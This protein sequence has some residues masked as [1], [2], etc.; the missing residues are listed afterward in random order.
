MTRAPF[1]PKLLVPWLAATVWT[2]ACAGTSAQVGPTTPQAET[3]GAV[4]V[5]PDGD[6]ANAAPSPSSASPSSL[7]SGSATTESAAVLGT[8]GRSGGEGDGTADPAAAPADMG[9][10]AKA[11]SPAVLAS[12]GKAQFVPAKTYRAQVRAWHTPPTAPPRR[13]PDGHPYLVLEAVNTQE[14]VELAPLRSDGGF[15]AVDLQRAA[16]LLRDHRA[17]RVLP[18]D[19]RALNLVYRIQVHFAAKAVR[20]LS[21]FRAAKRRPSNHSRGRAIDLMVPGTREADVASYARTLGFVGVGIYPTSGFVHLDTRARSYFWVDSSGPGQRTR[22]RPIY[23]REA[24]QADERALAR[25][26]S[27]PA[28]GSTDDDDGGEGSSSERGT[29]NASTAPR[30]PLE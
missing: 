14:R 8:P 29:Y 21:A 10:S 17:N 24:A 6:G 1:P 12:I 16:Y 7:P 20:V 28:N 30:R 11:V 15:S 9:A 4:S 23:A 22:T 2:S 26:E 19:P 27:P 13:T 18:I 3:S 5:P 25:G